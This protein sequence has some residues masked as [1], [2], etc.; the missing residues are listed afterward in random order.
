METLP[1]LTCSVVLSLLLVSV[2]ANFGK[3]CETEL[4]SVKMSEYVVVHVS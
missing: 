4:G 3:Y 1:S 2:K